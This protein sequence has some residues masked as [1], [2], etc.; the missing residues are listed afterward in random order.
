VHAGLSLAISENNLYTVESYLEYLKRLK[1][2][3]VVSI[4]RF[5][6]FEGLRLITIAVEALKEFGVDDPAKHIAIVNQG[7]RFVLLMS[8]TPFSA[9]A[10]ERLQEWTKA[11]PVPDTGIRIPLWDVFGLGFDMKPQVLYPT[12]DPALVDFDIPR[13]LFAVE[14]KADD[15]FIAEYPK[16]ISATTDNKPFFFDYQRLDELFSNPADHYIRFLSF[17]GTTAILALLLI[18]LPRFVLGTAA[19]SESGFGRSMLYFICL[20]AGFMT[21]EIGF[22][23]KFVLYLGHQ[24]YAVTVVLAT[25]LVAAGLGS[26]LAGKYGWSKLSIIRFR[27][28]PAILLIGFMLLLVFD[29]FTYA[30]AGLPLGIRILLSIAILAP[31]GF[32]LGIPFPS[33]LAVLTETAPRMVPWGI[34]INGFASVVATTASLPAAMLFGYK[35]VLSIGL[36][37]YLI[38]AFTFPAIARRDN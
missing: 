38:A 24:S 21:L 2:G 32:A 35:T 15:Q 9:A 31:L 30:T 4:L 11:A 13:Y 22:V 18:L 23:Q 17:I 14:N 10:L 7:Y 3:G 12:D 27:V 33:G 36:A 29:S 1:P 5:G 34:G 6:D 8:P 26:G 25:L 20:G 28:V 16:N 37:F 19:L